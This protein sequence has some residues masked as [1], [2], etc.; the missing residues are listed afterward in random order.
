[1][2][3]FSVDKEY[4]KEMLAYERSSK[5]SKYVKIMEHSMGASDALE[6]EQFESG[7][8]SYKEKHSITDEEVLKYIEDRDKAIAFIKLILDKRVLLIGS[9]KFKDKK[10]F[11]EYVLELTLSEKFD[12]LFLSLKLIFKKIFSN[13]FKK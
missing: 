10:E 5:I 2:S 12:F 3:K 8:K 13:I 6:A 4:E 7:A 9:I 1:M 11:S